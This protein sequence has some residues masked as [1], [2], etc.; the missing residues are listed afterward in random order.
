MR[1]VSDYWC[2]LALALALF[3]GVATA[4]GTTK[5]EIKERMK[6]RYPVLAELKAQGKIGETWQGLVEAVDPKEGESARVAN[7]ENADRSALYPLVAQETGT[8]AAA[9]AA[10]NAERVFAK[11]GPDEYF[12][13]NDGVWR[14]KKEMK[15]GF[16][17]TNGG[18]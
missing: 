2:A 18:R 12:K 8:T 11:A 4:E 1:N 10:I 17:T 14:Q 7:E 15:E 13:R 6:N 9:V 5:A 3:A 16:S